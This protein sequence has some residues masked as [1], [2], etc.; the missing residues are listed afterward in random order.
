[1]YYT[2]AH[3][4]NVNF[5]KIKLN[6]NA[7]ITHRAKKTTL[8]LVFNF[9]KSKYSHSQYVSVKFSIQEFAL[10]SLFVYVF[11]VNKDFKVKNKNKYQ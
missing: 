7:A 1:M 9:T 2:S 8:T 3:Q 6:E 10:K 4:I 5:F 11:D